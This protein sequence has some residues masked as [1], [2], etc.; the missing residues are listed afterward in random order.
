MCSS[1]AHDN[2]TMPIASVVNRDATITT[3]KLLPFLLIVILLITIIP[4]VLIITLS[5]PIG[6]R[7]AGAG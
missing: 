1:H 5:G 6:P 3:L 2:H 4:T 7:S